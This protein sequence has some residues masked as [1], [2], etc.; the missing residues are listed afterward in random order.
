MI[1]AGG[2]L[3]TR[4]LVL[5]ALVA[6]PFGTLAKDPPIAV[7]VAREILTPEFWSQYVD[8]TVAEYAAKYRASLEKRG[9]SVDAGLETALRE[10]YAKALPYSEV[11]DLEASLLQKHFTEAELQELLRF[12]QT[13]L[14]R[15]MRDKTPEIR[16]DSLAL[17][18]Q[19]VS[20]EELGAVMRP[21]FH[22]AAV[23]TKTDPKAGAC[24]H[25][26]EEADQ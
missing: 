3:M 15:K 8:S 22:P 9:G 11:L 7:R 6:G 2:S 25:D 5:L 16:R 13:P 1:R 21:H 17:S 4:T 19:K 10:Y 23:P 24:D 18:M 12:W 26:G 14:G 20:L